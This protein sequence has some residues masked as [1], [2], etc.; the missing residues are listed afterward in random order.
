MGLLAQ[1]SDSGGAG[2][3]GV[4]LLVYLA[5]IVLIV[6]S[7]WKISAK[8]GD[9]GWM[10]IIPIFNY[11]R[12]FARSRPEQAV[13]LTIVTLFCFIA[14]IIGSLDLA[15]LFGKSAGFGIGVVL[16]PFVFLPMLAF[17]NATYQGPPP[18]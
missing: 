13:L 12:I 17:G 2:G 16:L 18:P 5:I 7:L 9:P 15:K 3:L 1:A 11:Y 4:F 14:G 8:M 10:G 6:A